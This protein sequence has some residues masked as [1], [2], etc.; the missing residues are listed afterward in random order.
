M[1]GFERRLERLESRR[2]G[3]SQVVQVWVG[4][5]GSVH[6]TDMGTRAP[7]P[8]TEVVIFVHL[9]DDTLIGN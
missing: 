3:V 6:R 2:A 8:A 1:A 5:D 9:E 4:A 7:D